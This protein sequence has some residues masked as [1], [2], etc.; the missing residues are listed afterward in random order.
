MSQITENTQ[1]TQATGDGLFEFF[2]VITPGFEKL[3]AR[4]MTLWAPGFSTI[5]EH[6]GLRFLAPLVEGCELNRVL[7][8]PSR[9]L[10]RLTSFGCRDFPKLF[11]K[12]RRRRSPVI[13]CE[14]SEFR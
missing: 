1:L 7:K 4:E 12:T 8:I 14:G 6:G 9:L 3:A 10:L 11:K 13:C 5:A 2:A